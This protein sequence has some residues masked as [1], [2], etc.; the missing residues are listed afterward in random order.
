MTLS[1]T[2]TSLKCIKQNHDL[3]VST[4]NSCSKILVGFFSRENIQKQVGETNY[5]PHLWSWPWVLRCCYCY[6]LRCILKFPDFLE[7]LTMLVLIA[8]LIVIQNVIPEGSDFLITTPFLV[9][10][11]CTCQFSV[12]IWQGG[13]KRHPSD[14]TLPCH[15]KNCVSAAPALSVKMVVSFLAC[16][17]LYSRS[18]QRLSGS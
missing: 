18:L 13:T 10:D 6:Y 7:P 3:T 17:L 1:I 8:Y 16:W 2:S 11:H 5:R 15:C 14:Y 4:R 12:K 9:H